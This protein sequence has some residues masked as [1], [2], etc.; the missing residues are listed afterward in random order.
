[1][2]ATSTIRNN[3]N[4]GY[5]GG[6]VYVV[7]N[8]TGRSFT[9]TISDSDIWSNKTSGQYGGGLYIDEYLTNFANTNI[10]NNTA[11]SRA[12]AVYVE[13]IPSLSFT[14]CTISGNE[15]TS[16]TGGTGGAM[17]LNNSNIVIENS[18][19]TSNYASYKGGAFYTNTTVTFTMTGSVLS[20]NWT[21]TTNSD[22]GAMH[23]Q[24]STTYTITDSTISN[25][26]TGNIGGA[27]YV[28]GDNNGSTIERCIIS[29][30]SAVGGGTSQLGGAIY[31]KQDRTRYIRN[32]I[33]SGN[34]AKKG[35]GV[36]F[37]GGSSTVVNSSIIGNRANDN[38][39]GGGIYIQWGNPVITNS[40][41]W[42]NTAGASSTNIYGS[43]N[44]TYSN[45][46]DGGGSCTPDGNGNITCDPSF[47]NEVPASSAPTDT[48][49]YHLQSG[50]DCIDKG[51]S[52]GAPTDDID[53]DLRPQGSGYD[54]GADEYL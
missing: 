48:G 36:L 13:A 1:V 35:G 30:N 24:S 20:N 31:F 29:G 6:G 4:D 25:N 5:S 22:G 52:S 8:D 14:N 15:L 33:I 9:I 49:D 54:M 45:N 26:S 12:G 43:P 21:S 34:K 2:A 16:S 28:D 17:Y 41:I 50:S 37:N 46:G 42:G 18:T 47:V 11:L 10:S 39:A 40:I 51:T 27:F 44:I 32:C 38:G 19:I 7:D 53:G 23:I 3:Q